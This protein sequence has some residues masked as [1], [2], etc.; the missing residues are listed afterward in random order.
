[1]SKTRRKNHT[2]L[3][4]AHLRDYFKPKIFQTYDIFEEQW[5]SMGPKTFGVYRGYYNDEHEEDL[6]KIESDAIQPIRKLTDNSMLD[7]T[8]RRLV[9]RY[10]V[11]SL[12]RNSVHIEETLAG[13]LGDTKF[14]IADDI[15]D[16]QRSHLQSQVDS[17]FA[18]LQN[19]VD[20]IKGLRGSAP[21][22]SKL[23]HELIERLIGLTWHVVRVEDPHTFFLLSDFPFMFENLDDDDKAWL[24]FPISSKVFLY[25][26]HYP[27]E[28]WLCYSLKRQHVV[29]M[30]RR[31]VRVANRYLAAPYQA[32]W[33]PNLVRN[34]KADSKPT[35]GWDGFHLEPRDQWRPKLLS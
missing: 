24:R 27:D 20:F 32:T 34:M 2:V 16:A 6:A 13:V 26:N 18:R 19:D 8:E 31:L 3:P 23:Y 17:T 35:Y 28:K 21:D 14:K 30:S 33:I 10:V 7:E 15:P 29:D 4:E 12:F 5:I 22:N 9:S 11:A 25:F 1:M